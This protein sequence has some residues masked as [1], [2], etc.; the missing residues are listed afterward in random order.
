MRKTLGG[1]TYLVCVE[2]QDGEKSIGIRLVAIDLYGTAEQWLRQYNICELREVEELRVDIEE[3]SQEVLEAME[4][5][6][7]L[8]VEPFKINVYHVHVLGARLLAMGC[9]AFGERDGE[10]A[11]LVAAGVVV[12]LLLA[13][14]RRIR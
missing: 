6:G 4:I 10:G 3:L 5:H 8:R 14:V 1:K 13:L 12:I 11:C 7:G 9:G 2:V